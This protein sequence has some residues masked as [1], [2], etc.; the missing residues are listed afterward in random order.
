MAWL[1]SVPVHT[2]PFSTKLISTLFYARIITARQLLD[3][4][5]R[6]HGL[7]A[8]TLV[9]TAQLFV[10]TFAELGADTVRSMSARSWDRFPRVPLAPPSVMSKV[11]GASSPVAEVCALATELPA[12]DG[13][14][15][16][17]RLGLCGYPP[18]TLESLAIRT[19]LTRERVRQITKRFENEVAEW[20]IRL[21]RCAKLVDE[22]RRQVGV[23]HIMDA[24]SEHRR[25]LHALVRLSG[26]GTQPTLYWDTSAKAWM[27]DDGRNT[28]RR[29]KREVK[30]GL[31]TIKRLRRRWGAVPMSYLPC[32]EGVSRALAAQIALPS[33]VHWTIVDDL[34][35]IPEAKSTLARLA[36]KVIAAVGS[37]PV[38]RLQQ[39][40]EGTDRFDPPMLDETRLILANHA[41]FRVTESDAIELVGTP[42][43]E[44]VLTSAERTALAVINKAGGV[45]DVDGYHQEM[46]RAGI[47]TPLSSAILR[48]PFIVRLARGVYGLL[49][50][51]IEQW[52]IRQA[53]NARTARFWRSLVRFERTGQNVRLDYCLTRPCVVSG[54]LPL[55][56]S[57]EVSPGRWRANFPA[58]INGGLSIRSVKI[59]GLRSW[60]RRAGVSCESCVT[61]I[62]DENQR[63]IRVYHTN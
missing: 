8:P 3:E 24:R 17:S 56:P 46:E 26:L 62:I 47:S 33:Q 58:D 25:L 51:D 63:I 16:L 14:L 57:M 30:D 40:L 22:L 23:L 50:H 49:G 45:V 44:P 4:P 7:A 6:L 27:T 31:P 11:A 15:C 60:M 61:I 41:D 34:V 21:P 13:I 55:P 36:R 2:L 29:C 59:H 12:R 18:P 43:A 28:L 19:D 37:V 5:D 39:G 38:T 53:K 54:E 10:R 52:K 35:V 48:S 42:D 1:E 9:E 20:H 32:A